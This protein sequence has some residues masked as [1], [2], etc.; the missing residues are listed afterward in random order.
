MQTNHFCHGFA[1]KN[2]YSVKMEDEIE[3]KP[4][5]S[6]KVIGAVVATVASIA[7]IKNRDLFPLAI[8]AGLNVWQATIVPAAG[9][10]GWALGGLIEQQNKNQFV[11]TLQK[12]R[13]ESAQDSPSI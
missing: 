12:K 1:T 4:L 13:E 9:C 7:A 2:V 3:H 5:I 11:E 8:N 6:L 10:L